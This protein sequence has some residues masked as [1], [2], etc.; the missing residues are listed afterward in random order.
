MAGVIPGAAAVALPPAD[1]AI[2]GMGAGVT[3][4]LIS[5]WASG[6]GRGSGTG[7][8]VTAG[9]LGRFGVGGGAGQLGKGA[10]GGDLVFASSSAGGAC[11]KESPS[12]ASR[13]ATN[14]VSS[15]G[16]ACTVSAC[17]GSTF[18]GSL[19]VDS[20]PSSAGTSS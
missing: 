5:V 10:L 16:S 13:S 4:I 8:L 6:A 9:T 18:A 2:A 15:V 12:E 14:D 17:T 3:G 1:A 7:V 20:S 19:Y 11:G